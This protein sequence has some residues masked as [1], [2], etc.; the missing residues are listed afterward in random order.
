MKRLTLTI[1]IGLIWTSTILGQIQNDV[2]KVLV[3]KDFVEFKKFADSLTNGDKRIYSNCECLR[4]LTFDFQEGVFFFEKW[5]PTLENPAIF[6][7]YIFRV[8][9]IATKTQIVY[10]ELSEKK[11]KKVF[12]K[13]ESYYD[14]I[15]KFK[16]EKLFDSLKISFRNIFQ[17]ELN[18]NELFVTD[19]VYGQY[20]DIEGAKP[21]GRKQIDKWI[22][23]KNKKKL[24]NWLKST[25]TEK[26]VYAVTGL[27]QLKK[28]GI[29]LTEKEMKIIKFVISKNGTIS[30][31]LG[32]IYTNTNINSVTKKFNF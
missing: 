6:S 5:V 26:Q 32:C 22:A 9:I 10:Y 11:Y 24:L 23:F 15:D 28:K 30:I 7:D 3:T 17:K 4:D 29:K 31:C 18:E 1:L 12:N 27:F 25:N 8:N 19:F 20:C 14:L 21:I 2:K 16:D 13:S